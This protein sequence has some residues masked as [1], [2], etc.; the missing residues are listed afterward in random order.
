[1]LQPDL[2]SAL[3]FGVILVAALFWAGV[4]VFTIFLLISPG[5]SLILGFSAW[6]WPWR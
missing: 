3:I 4:P 6:A 1:M 2:G 5:I